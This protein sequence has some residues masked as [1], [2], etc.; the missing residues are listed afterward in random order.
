MRIAAFHVS[1]AVRIITF[2]S[3]LAAM[4]IRRSGPLLLLA[5]LL[6]GAMAAGAQNLYKWVDDKGHITYSDQPPPLSAKSQEQ[7]RIVTPV[8][9]NAAREIAK[10]D[11]QFKKRQEDAAKKSAE[12]TKKEQQETARAES[13]LRARGDLRAI[14]E[15]VPIARMSETGE[16]VVLD[17]SARE[18]EGRR[19][20]GFLEETC[21]GPTG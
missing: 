10:Q 15:N 19:I 2:L 7:V 9:A 14:R 18:S 1:G 13:C 3:R 17:A 5:P 12:A 8:N 4:K 6:V 16:R 21:A 11:T 20:E